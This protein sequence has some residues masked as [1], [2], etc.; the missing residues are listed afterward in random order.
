MFV[1]LRSEPR[2]ESEK[3]HTNIWIHCFFCTYRDEA[4]GFCYCND[5]V[6]SILKLL[7]KFHRV[8]YIDLD[9]HHGDG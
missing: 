4:A 3:G 8:L 6:L 7:E 9:I 1:C 5:V 2:S